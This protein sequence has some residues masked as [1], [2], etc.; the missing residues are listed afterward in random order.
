V[1]M[2]LPVA[3]FDGVQYAFPKA[4]LLRAAFG[5]AETCLFKHRI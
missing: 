2:G 1:G 4:E 3:E 5:K